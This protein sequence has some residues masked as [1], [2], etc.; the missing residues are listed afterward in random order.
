[1]KEDEELKACTFR[2]QIVGCNSVSKSSADRCKDLY[3]LA[4]KLT[5]RDDKTTDE[6]ELL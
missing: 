2:P 3:H 6:Y 1:M 5:K 4:K